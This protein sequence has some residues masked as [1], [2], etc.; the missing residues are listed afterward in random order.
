M[1]LAGFELTTSAESFI[2]RYL[3]ALLNLI[4]PLLECRRTGEK[5][6]GVRSITEEKTILIAMDLRMQ[7]MRI[8]IDA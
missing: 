7:Y 5:Y 6:S 4:I 1:G 3:H 8:A 2:Y